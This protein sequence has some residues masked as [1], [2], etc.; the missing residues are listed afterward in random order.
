MKRD[1]GVRPLWHGEGKDILSRLAEAEEESVIKN[2]AEEIKKMPP[3]ST[4][5]ILANMDVDTM[6][7]LLRYYKPPE[8]ILNSIIGR[9]LRLRK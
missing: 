8:W 1:K 2:I 4:V 6:R 3:E 9:R 7:V 5:D